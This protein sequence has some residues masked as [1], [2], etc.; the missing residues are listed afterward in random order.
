MK[1]LTLETLQAIVACESVTVE[2]PGVDTTV[3]VRALTPAEA[4]RAADYVTAGGTDNP[5]TEADAQV[6]MASLAI[7]TANFD[8]DEG[9]AQ[10]ARLPRPMMQTIA[11]AIYGLCGAD[12]VTKKN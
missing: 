11:N 6:Y 5:K 7:T 8:S 2:F 1:P 4:K 10:L 12:G 3:T 9:R